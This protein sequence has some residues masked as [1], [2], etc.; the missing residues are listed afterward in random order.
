MRSFLRPAAGL[1]C[2]FALAASGCSAGGDGTSDAVPGKTPGTS[3]APA[4]GTS[5]EASAGTA[6]APYVSATEA[7]ATDATGSP[8]TYN[9]A[10]VIADGSACTPSWNG[11]DA[12]GDATVTSRIAALKASGARVRVSFGGASGKDLSLIHI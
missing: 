2:L 5:A 1:T 9:L 10:F 3:A 7:S 4:P 11:T 8:A 12:I 6:Y